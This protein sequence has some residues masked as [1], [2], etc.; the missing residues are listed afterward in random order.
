MDL[1]FT[2]VTDVS[3]KAISSLKKLEKLS[4]NGLEISDKGVSLL[5]NHESLSSVD[6][7]GTQVTDAGVKNLCSI[8]RLESAYLN[9]TTVSNK[10]LDD[11]SGVRTLRHLGV[12]LSSVTPG[13]VDRLRLKMPLCVVDNLQ[14]QK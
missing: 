1:G 2:R 13:A 3:L 7:S 12:S 4:L 5:V 6:L 10:C 8:K 11:L 9:S 14:K